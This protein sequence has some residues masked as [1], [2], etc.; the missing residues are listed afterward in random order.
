MFYFKIVCCFLSRSTITPILNVVTYRRSIQVFKGRQQ[1]VRMFLR[2]Q[3]LNLM[4]Y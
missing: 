4:R 1:T 3:I 2:I